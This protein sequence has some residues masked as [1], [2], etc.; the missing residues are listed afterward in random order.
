M[1]PVVQV[2]KWLWKLDARRPTSIAWEVR[3][4]SPGKHA[5]ASPGPGPHLAFAVDKTQSVL[6]FSSRFYLWAAIVFVFALGFVLQLF[7]FVL[8]LFASIFSS[9]VC[10][11][12]GVWWGCF[13][14][15][16]GG[17]GGGL[18]WMWWDQGC[19]GL[20]VYYCV[21]GNATLSCFVPLCQR[22]HFFVS[23]LCHCVCIFSLDNTVSVWILDCLT[24][25][26]IDV[27][28]ILF[29]PSEEHK[30]WCDVDHILN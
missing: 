26:L 20:L 2:C 5:S 8:Q 15:G 25:W 22:W 9:F 6:L 17:R 3:K 27:V 30:I 23:L 7:A 28:H 24:T 1:S 16:G 14:F 21:L 13:F 29:S 10:V 11:F 12:W 4:M 19:L 18:L